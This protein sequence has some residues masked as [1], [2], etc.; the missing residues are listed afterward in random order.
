MGPG[1]NRPALQ[2]FSFYDE[3][4]TGSL[5]ETIMFNLSRTTLTTLEVHIKYSG[6]TKS[7][8]V[9]IEKLL[10][11]Y[12]YLK[13][14]RLHG[15]V[16]RYTP[17][18][19]TEDNLSSVSATIKTESTELP[20]IVVVQHPLESFT[21]GPSLLSRLGSDAFLFFKR[22]GNLKQI[23]VRSNMDYSECAPNS[24]P[25]DF[26]RALKQFCPKLESIDIEGPVV[27]WLFDLPILSYDQL[28]HIITM[29]QQ[30]P[31]Y[32]SGFPA[33]VAQVLKETRLKMQLLD[34]EQE[35]LLES[36]TAIPF[37]PQLKRLVLG[38]EHSLSVQ[39][40]FSLGVQAQFL[41]H[42]EIL[43]PPTQH[44]EPW[45]VYDKY[46]KN[47]DS[48]PTTAQL[49]AVNERA[50]RMID[51]RRRQLRRP[52]VNRD[53]MLFV[54]LCSS[55]RYLSLTGC[56]V[57]FEDLV[58]GYIAAT[59]P[60][61]VGTPFIR[62]WACEETLETLKIGFDVPH[63]LP[64]EHHAAI[65]KYLGRFKKLRSLS[66]VPTLC[67]RWVLI[68]TFD[69]GIEGL[70][71]EG[72]GGMSEML[73]KLELVSTWWDPA[74]GKQMV[75]WLAKACPKLRDLNLEYHFLFS[76]MIFSH[77]NVAHKAF[78]EDEEVKNC[79]LQNINVLSW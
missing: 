71:H 74:V 72:G 27:F 8:D 54:Q 55:L 53:M 5:L 62:P 50:I 57:T 46:D 60:G 51:L 16:F 10:E 31:S 38:G 75:L 78:L 17:M 52:F 7:Y 48:K 30:N 1:P 69:H 32:M 28:P 44:T 21:F 25:W 36:K 73:E 33:E 9:D 56:G 66:L 34:W 49:S 77:D 3:F 23:Q 79:T 35:E 11:T 22:L 37:F 4:L 47:V 14:L 6:T 42:L 18:L 63:D 43:R 67:P 58:E 12:P 45:E 13:D 15:L 20:V 59:S 41:T 40:L 64:K 24:R 29:V 2:H 39:D 65:W 76:D 70:F 26:G 68:P 19:Y 61:G